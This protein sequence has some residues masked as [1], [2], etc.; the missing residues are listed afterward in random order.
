[1]QMLATLVVLSV[2]G[3]A[4][5]GQSSGAKPP[6]AA[7]QMKPPTIIKNVPP[8][9]PPDA[10]AARIEGK[11]V[12]EATIGPAGTVSAAK[13]IRSIPMLDQ[14]AVD[15]VKQWVYEPTLLNGKAVSI[16]MTVTVTFALDAA[17]RAKPAEPPPSF[18]SLLAALRFAEAE[19]I[20]RTAAEHL[21]LGKRL[22]D[23]ASFAGA[24][25]RAKN[26][27]SAE[28]HL[29]RAVELAPDPAFRS[30]VIARL[31]GY[32]QADNPT[33]R[34][35]G[36]GYFKT[37]TERYPNEPAPHLVLASRLYTEKTMD[38]YVEEIRR[39]AARFP[40]DAHLRALV[41]S[42]LRDSVTMNSKAPEAQRRARLAEART[43]L[44]A[45]LRLDPE[46]QLTLLT[47]ALVL[48]DLAD[49]EKEPKRAAALEAEAQRLIDQQKALEARKPK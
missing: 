20:A 32:Y 1:M 3:A 49:F 41:G 5:A 19:A 43:E 6:A 15:A 28:D 17:A 4:F 9:Y 25:E 8:V 35:D 16:V 29:K 30:D 18:D 26:L 36:D 46:S 7:G 31:Q 34:A 47:K 42:A 14:A 48:R 21:E 11:V 45:A 24:A 37:L 40:K 2:T 39:V 38:A 33:R 12:I 27:A 44:D 23:T 13:V 22:A 10:Q